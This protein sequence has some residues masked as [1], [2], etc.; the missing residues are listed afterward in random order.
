MA[1]KIYRYLI[2]VPSGLEEVALDELREVAPQ[3]LGVNVEPGGR[4]GQIFFTF[5]RSP[6]QLLVLHSASQLAGLVCEMHR[7]TVGRPG[8]DSICARIGRID[9]EAVKSLA[10]SQ[11]GAIDTDV[12]TLSATLQGRY[13]FNTS[14]VVHAVR[15]VLCEKHGLRVGKGRG[16]LRFHLQLTGHRAILSLR[17]G[18]G[19]PISQTVAYCLARLLAMQ[20]G[21]RVLWT[22]RDAGEL[23]AINALFKP[24]VLVGLLAREKAGERRQNGLVA[25][26]TALPLRAGLIDYVL[27][28]AQGNPAEE[29]SEL[30]RI[31]RFGG[32]AIIQIEHFD[33]FMAILEEMDYP[34]V[35][36]AVLG[37]QEHG[38][39]F[40]LLIIERLE[41]VD[42]DLLQVQYDL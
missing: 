42:P 13:R 32:V 38:R 16:L 19:I 27:A 18:E 21:A 20:E 12:F 40:R 7:V 6:A 26:R 8:L 30:A 9:I 35:V 22:R 28:F 14:D 36:L 23:A 29:L 39:K 3:I 33:R 5:K 34:F 2:T 10:R 24:Q 25:L 11:P 37:L 1:D 4:I 17:L 15:T 31:L 41:E